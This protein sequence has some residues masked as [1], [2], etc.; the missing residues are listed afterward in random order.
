MRVKN[1]L[2]KHG[3]VD[4]DKIQDFFLRMNQNLYCTGLIPPLILNVINAYYFFL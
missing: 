4:A 3:E 1:D 2:L